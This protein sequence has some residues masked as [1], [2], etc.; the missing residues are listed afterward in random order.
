MSLERFS[1]R[2]ARF[3][4][5]GRFIAWMT[6]VISAWVAWNTML[7]QAWRFDR[8]PFIFL[9][10]ALSLQASYA[11]PLILLAQNR[12]GDADRARAEQDLG[13]DLSTLTLVQR[14]AQHLGV[15]GD[16][17]PGASA[18]DCGRG[19]T[20]AIDPPSSAMPRITS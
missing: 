2:I 3:L 1:E 20:S 6:V 18:S 12:Q 15:P 14:I 17:T 8:Y 10:F 16:Y 4:G 9:T 7:P 5:T 13:A 19:G 11:A